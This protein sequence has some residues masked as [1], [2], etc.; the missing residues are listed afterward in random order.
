MERHHGDSIMGPTFKCIIGDTFARIKLGDRFFYDL[1]G[2]V[3]FAKA[4]LGELRKASLARVFCD[5]ADGA[6]GRTAA[7]AAPARRGRQRRA[8]VRLARHPHR[9]PRRL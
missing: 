4:E 7:R 5:N 2:D 8:A 3:G 6:V 1:G 9:R